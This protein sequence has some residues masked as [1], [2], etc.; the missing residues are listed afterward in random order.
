MLA[1]PSAAEPLLM[2]LSIAFT[3]PTFQRVVPLAVGALLALGRR[4]VSGMVRPVAGLIQGHPSDY[5]RLFSRA[6]HAH[7]VWRWGHKWVV[8]AISVAF[9][10][11][12]RRWALP[13]LVALYRPED[14]NRTEGRRQKTPLALARQLTGVLLHWF[15]AR[16][17]ILVGDG[18]YASHEL[19]RFCWRHRRHVTL[20]SRFHPDANLYGAPPGTPRPSRPSRTPSRRFDGNSGWRRF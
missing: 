13:V 11:T 4:T 19:A 10:F 5:H 2:S 9:P 17:F 6:A 7:V 1:L 16:R 18:G 14:L 8:L 12:S 3:E 20:V 15:P